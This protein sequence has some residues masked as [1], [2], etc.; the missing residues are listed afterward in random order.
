MGRAIGKGRG[1]NELRLNTGRACFV[2]LLQCLQEERG[3][4]KQN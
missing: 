2:T 1:R 3:G 4:E